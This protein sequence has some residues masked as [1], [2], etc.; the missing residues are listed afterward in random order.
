MKASLCV[1]F[2]GVDGFSA[3]IEYHCKFFVQE[4]K[5]PAPLWPIFLWGGFQTPLEQPRIFECEPSECRLLQNGANQRDANCSS[6]SEL[7]LPSNLFQQLSLPLLEV[8][9]QCIGPDQISWWFRSVH[10]LHFKIF[11]EKLAGSQKFNYN[12]TVDTHT[13]KLRLFDRASWLSACWFILAWS[14]AVHDVRLRSGGRQERTILWYPDDQSPI[15]VRADYQILT[16]IIIALF[17]KF[18]R[19]IWRWHFDAA[20][21]RVVL[22]G[23]VPFFQLFWAQLSGYYF[24]EEVDYRNEAHVQNLVV[25]YQ[26][27]ATGD[28]LKSWIF[29]FWSILFWVVCLSWR[30]AF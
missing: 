11:S 4:T 15:Q 30:G 10:L 21:L 24:M 17:A 29:S 22:L 19:F 13:T 28:H 20:N 26:H 8:S 27:P 5:E 3:S 7:F 6:A 1:F 9:G 23:R 16:Y 12:A 18:H 14:F 25:K 2:S